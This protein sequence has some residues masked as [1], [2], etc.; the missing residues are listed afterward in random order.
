LGGVFEGIPGA[1]IDGQLAT[2]SGGF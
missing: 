1:F 2:V